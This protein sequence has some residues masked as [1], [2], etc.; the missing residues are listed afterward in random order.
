[1]NSPSLSSVLISCSKLRSSLSLSLL[2]V[3]VGAL[4]LARDI[5]DQKELE[6]SRLESLRTAKR[7]AEIVDFS[8][9]AIVREDL[10]GVVETWN[11]G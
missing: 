6:V 2:Q 11:R 9:D 4:M 1:M 5:T 7:M 3:V 8:D 10:N